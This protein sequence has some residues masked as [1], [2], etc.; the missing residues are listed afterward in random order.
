[1]LLSK[2]E[3]TVSGQVVLAGPQ[4]AKIWIPAWKRCVSIYE[5]RMQNETVKLSFYVNPSKKNWKR[6]IILEILE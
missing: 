4:K 3:T 2:G 6:K 1:M 5:Y